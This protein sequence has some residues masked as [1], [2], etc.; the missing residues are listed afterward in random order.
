[1]TQGPYKRSDLEDPV[2]A[3]L[4]PQHSGELQGLPTTGVSN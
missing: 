1:L 2:D 3:A 4:Q